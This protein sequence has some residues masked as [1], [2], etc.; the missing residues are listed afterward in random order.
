MWSNSNRGWCNQPQPRCPP[1]GPSPCQPN[2]VS[3]PQCLPPFL[4]RGTT[5]RKP[6]LLG[7]SLVGASAPVTPQP[8]LE[9]PQACFPGDLR[10]HRVGSGV[11]EWLF[12]PS[13]QDPNV[14][15]N[16]TWWSNN[17]E[18][19]NQPQPSCPSQRPQTCPAP[20]QPV[21]MCVCP[22]QCS[23][24]PVMMCPPPCQPAVFWP[25]SGQPQQC[26]P[27]WR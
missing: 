20:C 8:A 2:R 4:T 22:P 21:V 14:T 6:T 9:S 19:G 25:S 11:H 1:Q 26:P 15:S 27:Q 23:Q 7:Q 18:W 5:R 3:Q 17:T 10:W 12:V 24:P 13:L 16:T